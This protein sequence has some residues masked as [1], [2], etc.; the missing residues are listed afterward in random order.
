[1]LEGGSLKVAAIGN[2]DRSSKLTLDST[3]VHT[4][5]V[6]TKKELSNA[7]VRG[8][9]STDFLFRSVCG[10]PVSDWPREPLGS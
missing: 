5:Q 9:D 2:K 4:R 3:I 6:A 1:M 7:D 10:D 8:S